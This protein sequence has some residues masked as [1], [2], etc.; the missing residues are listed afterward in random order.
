MK[1][2]SF[3]FETR[4]TYT[5]PVSH[6]YFTLRCLPGPGEH[7][8]EQAYALEPACSVCE[9]ADGF[10]NRILYGTVLEP[11]DSFA[12]QVTGT[13]RKEELPPVDNLGLFRIQTE[14]TRPG[15]ALSGFRDRIR[16][17]GDYAFQ[18]IRELH[19]SFEYMP[20]A[21]DVTTTAETA[22]AQGRGV[23]QDMAHILLSLLR[24][25]GIP[26]RYVT[27]IIPGEG[28]SHAWVEAFLD[29]QWVSL[30]PTNNWVDSEN[31][32][33]FASGR[34]SRDCPIVRGVFRGFALQCQTVTAVAWENENDREN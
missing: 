34:D 13:V 30:D 25:E 2:L 20:G 16:K 32:V 26:C 31:T 17:T 14:M 8:L 18:V 7:L 10:G 1:E 21:T 12:F 19:D 5:K 4:V 28:Q 29:G 24:M 9:N 27:G 3:R 22:M 33:R 15:P 6:H 23:C 11:H